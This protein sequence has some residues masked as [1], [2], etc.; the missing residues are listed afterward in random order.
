M[1]HGE[2]NHTSTSSK[3]THI[4]KP[5]SQTTSFLAVEDWKVPDTS[6]VESQGSELRDSDYVM[7]E[8]REWGD[9]EVMD[10]VRPGRR[11][12]ADEKSVQAS[13]GVHKAGA[14]TTSEG[15]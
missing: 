8:D 15:G 6:L 7:V 12:I 9:K 14:M 1:P 3:R 13:N 5:I 11:C 2:K 4:Q 10:D